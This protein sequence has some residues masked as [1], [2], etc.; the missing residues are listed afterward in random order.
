MPRARLAALLLAA[1]FA[2]AAPAGAKKIAAELGGEFRLGKDET[3]RIADGRASLRITKFINSPC[4]KNAQC[5]W[6]GLAVMT[7]LRVDGKVVPP[8]AKDTPYDVVVKGSDY[9]TY[10]VFVVDEPERACS[11]P[12]AG[13][14]GECLRGL[15][16]RR[17]DPALCR[18][19]PD[20]RTRGFCLEDLAEARGEDRLCRE[21]SSPT[22]YCL[23]LKSK[24]AGDL[25]ACDGVVTR[26]SRVRCFKE[27]STEGGGGPR[28]CSELPPELAERC[29]EISLGPD[30]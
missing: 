24:A 20:A 8:G 5:V 10:A 22:Q 23:Y 1:L 6:S 13:H 7:E 12:G 17:S 3:A 26:S 18:K 16:R 21:V 4:P 11:R 25:A 29:R 27:L 28:S 14:L 30:R 19:V 15:A 9:R 2:P